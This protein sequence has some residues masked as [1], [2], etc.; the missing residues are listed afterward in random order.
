MVECHLAKVDVEGS[1]PFSR[2]LKAQRSL[3]LFLSVRCQPQKVVLHHH[4]GVE[5]LVNGIALTQSG[6]DARI[7]LGGQVFDAFYEACRRK[8]P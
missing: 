7:A 1:S 8:K 5:G 2:S 6:D 3:G 4:A